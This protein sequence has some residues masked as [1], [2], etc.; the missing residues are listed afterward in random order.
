MDPNPIRITPREREVMHLLAH[1]LSSRKI[2][3]EMGISF[4]T[5]ESYR[6]KLLQKFKSKTTVEMV[7][8]AG[9]VLP[10]EFWIQARPANEDLSRL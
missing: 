1:G 9:N 2:A 6:K 8:R 3:G 10:K 5:V 4:H 7:L